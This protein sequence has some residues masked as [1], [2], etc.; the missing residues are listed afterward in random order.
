MYRFQMAQSAPRL[1]PDLL[2]LVHKLILPRAKM[3]FLLSLLAH[4]SEVE[5][6]VYKLVEV[7]CVQEFDYVACLWLWLLRTDPAQWTQLHRAQLLLRMLQSSKKAQL[8][9][10]K[11]HQIEYQAQGVQKKLEKF[12][13]ATVYRV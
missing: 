6:F 9:R 4:L 11:I 8:H 10:P 1:S 7:R 2:L 12:G 3:N 5:P 13:S